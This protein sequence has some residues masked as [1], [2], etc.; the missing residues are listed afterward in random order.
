[1]TPQCTG[2]PRRTQA[3]RFEIACLLKRPTP[4]R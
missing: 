1:M 4:F 3:D 2:T